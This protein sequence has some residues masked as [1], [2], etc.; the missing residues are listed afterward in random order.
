MI[1]H[2]DFNQGSEE[3]FKIR[4]GRFGSTDAQA[5]A[6]NGR[7]LDTLCYQ[8]VAEIIIGQPQ[9][10]YTNENIERGIKLESMARSVYEIE[11]GN[12]VKQV[13][14]LE[15]NERIGCSPD[16]LVGKKGGVEIKCPNDKNYIRYLCEGKVDSKYMWQVQFFLY[17]TKRSWWD[18]VVFN[19]NLN[20]INITR[21]KPDKEAF[22]KI[23]LGLQSGIKKIE[24]V[25]KK[26]L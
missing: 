11:T 20:K 5:V 9:E 10:S 6:S 3:W 13:G 19:E 25:L 1:V 26:V 18:F 23:E 8:K 7:G 2:K 15:V 14:Y 21:I 12:L 17:I 4:L 22:S 24:E 16:G